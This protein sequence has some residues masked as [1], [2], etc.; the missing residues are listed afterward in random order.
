MKKYIKITPEG[1]KDFLFEECTAYSDVCAKIQKVFEDKGFYHVITPALEFFDLFSMESSGIMQE[2][3]YKTTD[4]KGRL[5]V[6]RPDSTLPIA[7]LASTRLK[8]ENMPVRLYYRQAVYRNNLTLTGKPNEIMQMGVELLGVEGKRADL[9]V[10]STAVDCLQSIMPD[11]RIEI[12]HAGFFQALADQ[13]QVSEEIKENIRLSIENKNYSALNNILDNL[14]NSVAVNA[15]RKLPRLFG[16]EEVFEKALNLSCGEKAEKALAYLQNIYHSLAE[17][18]LENKIII[19][20]GLVQRNDYYSGIVFTGYVSGIGDAVLSG[21]RY[22]L[23]LSNFGTP[24]GAAGFA[25]NVDAL[26]QINL[27]INKFTAAIP[28]VLVYCYDGYEIEAI[29]FS[30]ELSNQGKKA[31]FCVLKNKADAENYAK[32]KGIANIVCIGENN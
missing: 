2:S 10:L 16:G 1:S 4:N 9:E 25:I 18:G 14:P 8:N 31:Q 22:D 13:L 26:A 24:M 29:K 27:A 19:D 11:F 6:V 7:R 15:I 12:G 32:E 28:D 3:M 21:G 17:L 30:K 23:L 5:L 20:L